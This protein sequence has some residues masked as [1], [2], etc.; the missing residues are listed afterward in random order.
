MVTF[1]RTRKDYVRHG[2]VY[3]LQTL[4]G[5]ANHYQKTS[6]YPGYP[7][8]RELLARFTPISL[9]ERQIARHIGAAERDGYI[10]RIRRHRRAADGHL[11]LRS[12]IYVITRRLT[13]LWRRMLGLLNRSFVKERDCPPKPALTKTAD[14][15][16][17]SQDYPP[18][19]VRK[20]PPPEWE[21]MKRRLRRQ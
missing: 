6:V 9:S 11:I 12:T 20:A 14:N 5:L 16:R 15:L 10:R 17:S 7:K 8:I 4:Q 21:E 13:G 3:V 2:N 18:P 1:R 19:V